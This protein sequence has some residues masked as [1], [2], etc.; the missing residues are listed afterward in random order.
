MRAYLLGKYKYILNPSKAMNAPFLTERKLV[1]AG[2][3][4]FVLIHL[5]F[6]PSFFAAADEHEYLKNAFLL[7]EGTLTETDPTGVCKGTFNGQGYTSHFFIGRSLFL[8]PFTFFGFGAV[9]LSGLIIHLLNMGMFYAI[10]KKLGSRPIYSLFYLLYPALYWE[11]RT[12]NSE[13]LVLTGLLAGVYFYLSEKKRDHMLS[14]IFFGLSS[15]VRYEAILLIF[16]FFLIPLIRNR[17]KFLLL[18]A[19]FVPVALLI[20]WTN[21]LFYGGALSTGYGNPFNQL[22]EIGGNPH[23]WENLGKFFFLL[24]IAYPLLIFSPAFSKTLRAELIL[25]SLFFLIFYAENASVAVFPTFHPTAFTGQLRY[26]V[27]LIGLLMLSYPPFFEMILRKIRLPRKYAL[28][29]VLAALFILFIVATS[30]HSQFLEGRRSV[31][32]QIY[33]HTEKGSLLI[34]SADDCNY[35]LNNIFEERHYRD[36]KSENLPAFIQEYQHVYVLDISYSTVDPSTERG[37]VALAERQAI[38]DF[39]QNNRSLEKIFS[40]SSPHHV[41]IYRLK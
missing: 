13:L 29:A 30:V 33:S 6:F 20:L 17:K 8:I 31:F 5:L 37:A 12:L 24:S 15:L 34:G 35:V 36:V 39:I 10:L 25:A 27:P 41:E 38:K 28:F 19:G 40:S 2:I 16:P 26:V 23:F 22:T 1:V 9:M 7:R 11:A 32:D 21:S 4:L 3:V 14:G 18:A